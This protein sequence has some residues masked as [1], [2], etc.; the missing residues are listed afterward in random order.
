MDS[1][2][3]GF[4]KATAVSL[5]LAVLSAAGA[6]GACALAYSDTVKSSSTDNATPADGYTVIEGTN[7][8]TPTTTTT[9]PPGFNGAP[10]APGSGMHT[11][12]RGS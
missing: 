4:R 6:F 7:P 12:S 10:L 9:L 1:P 11:R 2:D 3:A 5:G 8:A